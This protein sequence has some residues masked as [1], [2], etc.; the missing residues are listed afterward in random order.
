MSSYQDYLNSEGWKA[1]RDM[2][3][4]MWGY[5]CAL[6]YSNGELHLHHRTYERKGSEDVFD[7]IP[8]C[9]KHHEMTHDISIASDDPELIQKIGQGVQVGRRMLIGEIYANE[10]I[11]NLSRQIRKFLLVKDEESKLYYTFLANHNHLPDENE[12]YRIQDEALLQAKRKF[13]EPTE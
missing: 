3:L 10:K 9:K 6:C 4:K 12:F 13:V 2:I 7:L 1:K 8:L 5:R 11:L